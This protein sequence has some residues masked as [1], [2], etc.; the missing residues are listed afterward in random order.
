MTKKSTIAKLLAEEDITVIHKKAETASFD[1]QSREL[2]LPI[3]KEDISNNLYDMFVCHEVGHALWTPLTMIDA[4]IAQGIDKSVVNVVEDARIEKMFM[5]KYPGSVRNFK[6][7]YQELLDMDIFQIKGKDLSKLNIIDKINIY[8]KT[9]LIGEVTD[10]EQALIDEVGTCKTPEDVLA[11]SAKLCAWYKDNQEEQMQQQMAS[12]GMSG[13]AEDGQED[14][15]DAETTTV[16]IGMPS[17]DDGPEEGSDEKTSETSEDETKEDDAETNKNSVIGTGKVGNS[18]LGTP[19]EFVGTLVS[20]TDDA[21]QQAMDLSN[22][23]DAR[24]R[25]YAKLPKNLNLAKM[26]VSSSELI[27]QLNHSFVSEQNDRYKEFILAEHNKLFNDNKKVVQYMVKEFEMK[28]SADLYK[29]ASTSKTGSL[30]MTKLHSYKFEEDIFA[31]MTNIPHGQNHGMIMFVDWSGSMAENMRFTLT[32]LFNLVWFC[33]RTQIPFQVLAFTDRFDKSD[34]TEPRWGEF[35]L[36]RCRLLELFSNK[37]KK[38]DVQFMMTQL[39]GF[40]HTWD[41]RYIRNSGTDIWPVTIP[42]QLNLG[43]TPLDH[44]IA[45]AY[46]V[47]KKFQSENSVQKLNFVFLTDG[48]SNRLEEVWTVYEDKW[49]PTYINTSLADLHITCQNTGASVICTDRYQTTPALLKL[50]KKQCPDS[51]ILGFFVAGT[52]ANGRIQSGTIMSKMNIGYSSDYKDKVAEYRAILRKENVLIATQ[53]GYDEYYI[54]PAG[55]RK[56]KT[57]ETDLSFKEGARVAGMAKEFIKF[58]NQKKLNRQLLNKFV[59]KVA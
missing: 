30:D 59:E 18:E 8:Y 44:A 31:K 34:Y 5:D 43:M 3:F 2:T 39:L 4:L 24:D 13:D 45:S 27:E 19:G 50:L 52:G 33:Q 23:T 40:C 10:E 22:D 7:G 1:V 55:P 32:Q 38:S 25:Q 17:S 35:D 54:L 29:R 56:S 49:C 48:D 47:T 14:D 12:M 9:G 41:W 28:K 46:H 11:M 51:N 57:E 16:Q 20:E 26:I 6:K 15:E 53:Q 37:M 21:Y 58:A 36:S 42:A